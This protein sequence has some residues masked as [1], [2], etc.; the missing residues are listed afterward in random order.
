MEELPEILNA[1]N[2]KPHGAL[3]G[4]TSIEVFKQNK[5][6]DPDFYK[7][8]IKK[9]KQERLDYYRNYSCSKCT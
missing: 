1:Y 7:E 4:L 8:R 3:F 6:P 5:Q 9:A 2:N